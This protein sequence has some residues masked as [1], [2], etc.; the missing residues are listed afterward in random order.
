M[1]LLEVVH[2]SHADSVTPRR[3]VLRD[4]AV[5]HVISTVCSIWYSVLYVCI[6]SD[7]L[8]SILPAA[9]FL[10]VCIGHHAN[11]NENVQ[12]PGLKNASAD[13]CID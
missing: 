13:C 5:S 12:E 8:R 9:C 11:A 4:D 6:L 3:K 2:Y 10:L 1:C 7:R